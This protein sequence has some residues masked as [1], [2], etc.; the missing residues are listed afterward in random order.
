MCAQET[1]FRPTRYP[2]QGPEN[3]GWRP[4]PAT[5]AVVEASRSVIAEADRGGFRL[6]LR[7]VFYGLVSRH[8]IPNTPQEYKRLPRI[9]NR[10]R[11]AGPLPFGCIDDLERPTVAAKTWTDP[12]A[13]LTDAV[14]TYHT[15][16]V[17]S[18][19]REKAWGSAA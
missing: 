2:S 8:T 1:R 7:A 13:A 16:P 19:Y 18:Q 4:R 3:K 14:R 12:S 5:M 9:L 10:A 17:A 11:W 6:T 15:D